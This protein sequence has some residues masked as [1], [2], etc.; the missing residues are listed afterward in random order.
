MLWYASLYRAVPGILDTYA[1]GMH[2][3][4]PAVP[5]I[6]GYLCYGYASP[7]RAVPGILDTYAMGMHHLVPVVPGVLGTYAMGMHHFIEQCLAYWVLMLWYA[8]PCP[9]SAWHT[10]YAIFL[11]TSAPLQ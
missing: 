11:L 2:H 8:S 9:S 4:V 3:L 7:Y 6:P 5:G 10:G 1:M